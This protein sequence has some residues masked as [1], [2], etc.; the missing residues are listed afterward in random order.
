MRASANGEALSSFPIRLLEGGLHVGK[1]RDQFAADALHDRDNRNRNAG[2]NEPI[3]DGR[4]GG[5]VLEEGYEIRHCNSFCPTRGPICP[6]RGPTKFK[7]SSDCM[8]TSARLT[9]TDK[10][11]R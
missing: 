1:G 10:T 3:F 9:I 11:A 8:I 2:R 4:R 5:F 7:W 6:T